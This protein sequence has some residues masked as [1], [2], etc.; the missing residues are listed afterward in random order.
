MANTLRLLSLPA[1][2]LEALRTG[3]VTAGHARAILT[4]EGEARRLALLDRVV[5]R[6]LSVR[7]AEALARRPAA[8]RA[9]RARP[10]DP[11]LRA[12]EERL[13]RRLG[14]RVVLRGGRRKG[15]GHIAIEYRNL[16]DL[17]R[18]LGLLEGSPKR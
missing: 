6:G 7:E 5:R 8:P 17:D 3:T 18:L 4:V 13:A 14:T 11:N 12:L 16:D 2:V 1:A 10:R 15:A 9:E